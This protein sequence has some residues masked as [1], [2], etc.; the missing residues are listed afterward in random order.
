MG[1]SLSPVIAE[2]FMENLE[3]IAFAGVDITIKPR[4][5]KRYVDDIFVVITNGKEDQFLEYLNSLF[6]EQISFTMEKESNRTL[7]FLDA[8][9]I[10]HDELV[11]TTVYRKA[12][13]S[14]RYLDF[15][16]HHLHSVFRSVIKG[17]VDR[18]EKVCDHEFIQP[19]LQYITETLSKKRI[20]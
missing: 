15:S 12:T 17:V 14:E 20:P 9:V 4:F 16:S 10:R 1:N 2:V 6:P 11:Q 5:F 19:E 18:A 8:L 13:Q 3:E 7:P